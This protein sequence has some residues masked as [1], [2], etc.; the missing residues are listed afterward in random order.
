MKLDD[1]PLFVPPEHLTRK[2]RRNWNAQEANEYKDWIKGILDKRLEE[3]TMRFEEPLGD[4]PS[5]HLNAL[6]KKVVS[7]LKASPFSEESPV[8]R[9]LTNF[10]YALAA[11]MGLL[12]AFYLLKTLKG[13]IYWETVAKPKSEASYNLPVLR[14]FSNNYLDPIAGSIAE[15]SAVL[16]GKRGTDAWNRIFEYWVQR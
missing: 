5:L 11:D 16:R 8:G 3:L 12:V 7:S 15:S 6:G 2:G 1:Y 13:K 10:G 9:T 14:G 4:N